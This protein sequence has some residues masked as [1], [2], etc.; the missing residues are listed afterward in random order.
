MVFFVSI[1]FFSAFSELAENGLVY[2]FVAVFLL[3]NMNKYTDLSLT[4]LF[5]LKPLCRYELYTMFSAGYCPFHYPLALTR[6]TLWQVLVC[7]EVATCQ[8]VW[9]CVGYLILYYSF[10]L[11]SVFNFNFYQVK[12]IVQITD[13]YCSLVLFIVKTLL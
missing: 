5:V 4:Y 3:Q 12:S 7:F 1:C 9:L 8:C 13:V 10:S 2:G 11:C 6:H